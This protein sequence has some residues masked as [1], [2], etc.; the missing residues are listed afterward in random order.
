[1]SNLEKAIIDLG[2]FELLNESTNIDKKVVEV[3]YQNYP[4]EKLI[5]FVPELN[6]RL[7]EKNF[8]KYYA[9]LKKQIK[10]NVLLKSAQKKY[11]EALDTAYSSARHSDKC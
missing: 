1:M 7:S 8:K 5:E 2:N 10:H 9:L 4:V 3:A 6:L 11:L